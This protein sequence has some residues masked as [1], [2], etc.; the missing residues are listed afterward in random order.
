[1]KKIHLIIGMDLLGTLGV[2]NALGSTI[3]FLNAFEL[4]SGIGCFCAMII[5]YIEGNQKVK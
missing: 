3:G 5:I 1:M 2:C 4:A